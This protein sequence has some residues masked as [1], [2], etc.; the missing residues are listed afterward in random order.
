[1]GRAALTV[2]GVICMLLPASAGA[3]ARFASPAGTGDCTQAAPCSL[4][5]AVTLA[6]AGDEVVV[7]PG[8]HAPSATL[9]PAAPITIHGT[10]GQ[11][12]PQ[13]VGPGGSPVLEAS[14]TLALADLT[15]QSRDAVA[16]KALGAG[17]SAERVEAVA[18]GADAIALQAGNGFVLRNSLLRAYGSDAE[19]LLYRAT[20]PSAVTLRNV[21]AIAEGPGTRGVAVF[22]TDAAVSAS[23]EAVNVIADAVIDVSARQ[24]PGATSAVNLTRSNYLVAEGA[25]TPEGN[26]VLPP[27][28]ANAAAGEFRQAPGSPTIDAGLTDAANGP[29]DLDGIPR[30]AGPATDIG[31]YE[32]LPPPP[33]AAAPVDMSAAGTIVGALR[34]SRSGVVTATLAC[35]AGESRCSWSYA[36]RSRKRIRTRGKR[37]VIAF[38]SG[39][40]SAAGGRRVTVRIRLSKRN[41]RLVR[42]KRRLAVKL[43][44]RTTDAAANRAT[45]KRSATLKAPKRA[46]RT[47]RAAL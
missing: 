10:P 42:Q 14:A 35:P 27:R 9:Q 37:R 36:L 7:G 1:M 17:S 44:V 25:V 23:I 41:F 26:Q 39:R 40:A 20:E 13:I 11:A 3:E 34:L 15:F 2:V 8:T 45:T 19:A 6:A 30:T 38:G 33:A 29:L 5:T 22:A 31:A 46:A 12:R 32:S 4:E 24:D 47:R 21:T 16:V 18:I 43:T 28:F